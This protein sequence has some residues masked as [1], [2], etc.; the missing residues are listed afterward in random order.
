MSLKQ[1][2]TAISAIAL[3][4]FG[5]ATQAN[6]SD[7]QNWMPNYPTSHYW[8][9]PNWS[10]FSTPQPPA[11]SNNFQRPP[12]AYNNNY[13]R[14]PPPSYRQP[15][16]NYPDPR[17]APNTNANR[18]APPP[19]SGPYNNAPQGR[20]PGRSQGQAPGQA[21]GQPPGSYRGAP[22][23]SQYAPQGSQ[24]R[25]PSA[26]N[27]PGYNPYRGNQGNQG[28]NNNKL[29]GRSGPSTWMNP[30]KQN[31]EN[32]WDDMINSPSRMGEMPG[33]WTAPEVTMPNPIDMGDQ[34]QDNVKDL[35][36][37]MRE[38]NIGNNV[39]N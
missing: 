19:P 31:W 23:P 29:W 15:P 36:E 8:Q 6:N 1:L 25:G 35:P 33:G 12:P 24:Y 30:S 3:S 14:P 39:T 10:G 7:G 27:T 20:P 5:F 17:S 21:M 18:M 38:G 32:A 37:Q 16:V 11:Y 22:P 2:S 9:A 28:W 26:F 34:F 13:R 4:S